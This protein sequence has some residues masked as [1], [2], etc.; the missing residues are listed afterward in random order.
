M[1]EGGNAQTRELTDAHNISI[2]IMQRLDILV[3]VPA[4]TNEPEPELGEF[5]S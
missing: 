5:A 3:L 2:P 4:H 1:K